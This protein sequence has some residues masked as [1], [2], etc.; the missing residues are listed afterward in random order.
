[1]TSFHCGTKRCHHTLL[2][3]SKCRQ[4][5]ILAHAR[6]IKIPHTTHGN[7]VV[8]TVTYPSL[9]LF[10][11]KVLSVVLKTTIRLLWAHCLQ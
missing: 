4:T 5:S 7:S 3:S 6:K 10:A 1:M 9:P 11:A 2:G 8:Y